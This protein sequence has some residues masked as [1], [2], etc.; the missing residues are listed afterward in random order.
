MKAIICIADTHV[1]SLS[2][3]CPDYGFRLDGGAQFVP[4]RFVKEMWKVWLH[5]WKEYVPKVTKGADEVIVVHNGDIID[6]NHHQAVD[7]IPNVAD[8]EAAAIQL[9]KPIAD[10][11]KFYMIRGTEAHCEKSNQ[12]TERIAKALG[13]VKDETIDSSS[14]WQLWIDIEGVVHQFAHHIGTTSSAT[15]ESS[16]P[17]RELVA[18]LVEAAQ[19]G[20]PMPDVVTRSHR[21]RYISV[22]IPSYK[23]S[24]KAVITP[25][26][27]LRTPN[28]ERID[29]M[30]IAHIGGVIYLNE[31]KECQIKHIIYQIQPPQ[32]NHL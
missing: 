8:Q 1:G 30:R 2:G 24:I 25:A 5:F 15:Y 17:M 3:L 32:I 31:E 10:R 22:E 26:W 7:L 12:S 4:N 23:G 27:Q 6:G 16:A 21:H 19:W 20:S 13:C 29:R 14:W 18:G 28:I 11:Y 9:F